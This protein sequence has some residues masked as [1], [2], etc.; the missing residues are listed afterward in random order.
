M[1]ASVRPPGPA[2][3]IAILILLFIS[4]PWL[5]CIGTYVVSIGYYLAGGKCGRGSFSNA[6]ASDQSSFEA[7]AALGGRT[8][9]A[10]WACGCPDACTLC[11][12]RRCDF[13]ADGV[14]EDGSY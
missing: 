11:V 9:S 3:T 7:V 6:R 5:F 8:V 1:R 12:K 13:D 4:F 14:G 10:D 2:P